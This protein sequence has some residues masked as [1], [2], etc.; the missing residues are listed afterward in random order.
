VS[1]FSE[2]DQLIMLVD[3]DRY[4]KNA[5]KKAPSSPESEEYAS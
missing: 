1:I 4:V 5:P 2:K 3:K